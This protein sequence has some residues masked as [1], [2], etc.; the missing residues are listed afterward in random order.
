MAA[1]PADTGRIEKGFGVSQIVGRRP[2]S[3]G[4]LTSVAAIYENLIF[5]SGPFSR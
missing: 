3:G 5:T 4:R 1:F 2:N